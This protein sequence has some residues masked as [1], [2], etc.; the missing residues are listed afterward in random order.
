MEITTLVFYLFSTL[1]LVSAANVIFSRQAVSA[2]L[3]LIVSFLAAMVL[4]LLLHAEFLGLALL[5]VYV[6]AVMT[7]FL[8]VVMMLNV[9][10]Q[11][12][13]QGFMKLLPVAVLTGVA[14][15]ATITLALGDSMH[16]FVLDYPSDYNNTLELGK[17]LYTDYL[18]PLE[19]A[20]VILLVA[21]IAA[22]G[23]AFRGAQNR[24]QQ[25]VPKQ[26]LATKDRQ[27]RIISMKSEQGS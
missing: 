15:V 27:L 24:K 4:W 25:D 7:L 5:F 14:L 22:I 6:G 10:L 23:L 20:A 16:A 26:I 13:Y 19:L 9:R 11:A 1:L 21:I 2:V 12:K 17:V 8:F 18:V 3:S